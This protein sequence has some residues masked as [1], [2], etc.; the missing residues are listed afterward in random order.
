MSGLSL[1]DDSDTYKPKYS[2]GSES[3]DWWTAYPNQSAIAGTEVKHPQWVLD[4]LEKKP[5]LIMDHTTDCSSC[6]IQKANIE[7][8]LPSFSE[9]VTYYDIL[10]DGKDKKAFEILDTYNPTGGEQFV[11]TTVF[12]TLIKGPD[13]KVTVAWHSEIDDMTEEQLSAYLK[14]AVYYYRQN[15][16]DWSQ[17]RA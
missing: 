15:A 13:G 17:I 12:I 8:V 5:V 9:N 7:K 3:A 1:A 4:A 16:D 14:D 6:K 11:P 2:I 10:A